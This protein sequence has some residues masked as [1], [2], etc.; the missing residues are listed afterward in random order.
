MRMIE[1]SSWSRTSSWMS[2]RANTAS[3]RAAAQKRARAIGRHAYDCGKFSARDRSAARVSHLSLLWSSSQVGGAACPLNCLTR[4]LTR[5]ARAPLRLRLRELALEDADDMTSVFVEPAVSLRAAPHA[6]CSLH[7]PARANV[8][9]PSAA[10]V[11]RAGRRAARIAAAADGTSG[12]SLDSVQQR[13][14][15]IK[16]MKA[17]ANYLEL[18]KN[19]EEDFD[20][21]VRS[22][23]ISS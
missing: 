22:H 3:S 2:A 14:L 5:R 11:A 18:L 6:S 8:N 12:G 13:A 9:T 23:T 4:T 15:Q 20:L 17:T 19:E 21:D 1:R 16:S 10:R 7:G